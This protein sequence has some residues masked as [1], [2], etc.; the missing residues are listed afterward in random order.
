MTDTATCT[1]CG[2]VMAPD[3]SCL[4]RLRDAGG[5]LFD[6][7]PYGDEAYWCRAAGAPPK[8]RRPS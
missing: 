4:P 3:S 8:P 2:Q 6:R 1:H 7:I 5:H